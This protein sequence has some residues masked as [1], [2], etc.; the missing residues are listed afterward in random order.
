ML[1]NNNDQKEAHCIEFMLPVDSFAVSYFSNLLRIIQVAIRELAKTFESAYEVS[2]EDLQSI[3]H[4]SPVI[5]NGE[6]ILRFSFRHLESRA[7]ADK[8]TSGISTVFFDEL[9]TYLSGN[10][11]T[12]LW[13]NISP[14]ANHALS[15][16]MK[17]RFDRIRKELRRI[18]GSSISVNNRAIVFSEDTFKVI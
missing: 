12:D 4:F 2:D 18:P 7:E 5:E 9:L 15:D 14:I 6:L 3:L 11:Q 13:G 8:F 10:A 16:S 17:T 1:S